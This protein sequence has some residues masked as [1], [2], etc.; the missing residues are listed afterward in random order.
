MEHPSQS[1]IS[2]LAVTHHSPD[3]L[4]RLAQIQGQGLEKVNTLDLEHSKSQI[5]RLKLLTPST[6]YQILLRTPRMIV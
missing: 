1:S 4:Q 3:H 2:S 5:P 6:N